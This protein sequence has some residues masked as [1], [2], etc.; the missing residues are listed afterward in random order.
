MCT[1]AAKTGRKEAPCWMQPGFLCYSSVHFKLSNAAAA[2]ISG[3]L[4]IKENIIVYTVL[5]S[6]ESYCVI[7]YLFWYV[8]QTRIKSALLSTHYYLAVAKSMFGL[9]GDP[10]GVTRHLVATQAPWVLGLVLGDAQI[11]KSPK[12]PDSLSMLRLV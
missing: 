2:C 11:C 8:L 6:N 7:K 9:G 3:Y 5:K 12:R 1:A 4:Y 10:V